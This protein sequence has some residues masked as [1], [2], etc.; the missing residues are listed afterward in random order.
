[1]TLRGA[2]YRSVVGLL[3]AMIAAGQGRSS[4]LLTLPLFSNNDYF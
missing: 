4:C 3:L 2:A 1:M